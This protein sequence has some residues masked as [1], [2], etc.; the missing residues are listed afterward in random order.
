MKQ[1][2]ETKKTGAPGAGAE[3]PE[4]AALPEGAMEDVSGGRN[5]LYFSGGKDPQPHP[6]HGTET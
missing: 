1:P 6:Y 5:H 3:A 2:D 4:D